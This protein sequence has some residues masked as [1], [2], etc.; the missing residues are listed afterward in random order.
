MRLMLLLPSELLINLEVKS[1]TAEA[2]DGSFC[3]LPRHID[4]VSAL[5]PG[6]VAYTT[7]DGEEHFVAVDEGILVKCG[8]E[9]S[10]SVRNAVRHDVLEELRESVDQIFR[11]QDEREQQART[12]ML[13]LEAGLVQQFVRLGEG[14][15][16]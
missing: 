8:P 10:I 4:Y 13:R 14:G 15:H 11:R 7:A 12:A 9:V 5:A 1:V 6:I 2:P 3:L 16:G